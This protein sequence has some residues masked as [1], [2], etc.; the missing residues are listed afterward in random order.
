[1][2]IV[3]R[4]YRLIREA[5]KMLRKG[6]WEKGRALIEKAISLCPDKYEGHA[7]LGDYYGYQ[8]DFE[9]AIKSF[10][11]ALDKNPS[12]AL[13]Y[14]SLGQCL[15]KTNESEEAINNLKMAINLNPK[16]MEAYH[17]L[18]PELITNENQAES[19]KYLIDAF[20]YFPDDGKINFLL[21]N[22]LIYCSDDLGIQLT[23]EVLKYLN[24]AENTGIDLVGINSLRGDY[25]YKLKDWE[26]AAKY[27]SKSLV[28]KYEEDIALKYADCLCELEDYDLLYD[29]ISEMSKDGSEIAKQLMIDHPECFDELK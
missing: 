26:N 17:F 8:G 4:Y 6:K 14:C 27:F 11:I 10:R 18:I 29:L 1:M 15:L 19:Y 13:G 25:Y 23:D 9:L 24:K 3:T 5:Q 7:L 21:A 22:K 12:D 20:G 28:R 16:L 2:D